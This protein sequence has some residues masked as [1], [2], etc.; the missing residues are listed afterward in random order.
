MS[1]HPSSHQKLQEY[2]LKFKY[3]TKLDYLGGGTDGDVWQ[4]ERDTAI[5]LFHRQH[6]YL[7]ER[8]TYLRL[9]DFGIV[10]KIDH[11]WVPRMHHFDDQ[12]WVVEMDVMQKPPYIID[13]A[14]VKLNHPPDFSEDVLDAWEIQ[15]QERF[16]H[17]WPEVKSL[18]RTLESYLI[19]YLDPQPGNIVFE[20]LQ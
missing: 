10:E 20:D 5:K 13:F 12:L 4:T 14:K 19:Y 9:A 3:N 11:F 18:L 1:Y 7:N 15:G 2:L 8:D 6:G 17:H 16:E